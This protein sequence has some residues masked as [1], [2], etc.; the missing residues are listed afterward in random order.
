MSRVS[1][2]DVNVLFA[3]IYGRHEHSLAAVQWLE[4]QTE[5]EAILV[6][7][8]TEMGAL[9]LLTTPVVMG[10]DLLNPR[11]ALD[12]LKQLMQDSRFTFGEESELLSHHW[13]RIIQELSPKS[14]IETDTY[15]AAFTFSHGGEI[16]TFDRGFERFNGLHVVTLS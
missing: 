6:C 5:E 10:P 11:Q 7:R 8:T 12:G 1:V 9:R 16:V 14:R 2:L 4:G 15:L 3:L 13:E